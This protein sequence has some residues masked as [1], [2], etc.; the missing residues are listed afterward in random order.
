MI[1]LNTPLKVQRKLAE[2]T[3]K[4]RLQMNLTQQ[5]LAER[6]GVAL[7][8]L[9]KFEQVGGISLASFLKIQMVLGGLEDILNATQIKEGQFSSIDEVLAGSTPVRQR[10]KRR[11]K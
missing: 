5:E 7:A 4:R 9:R 8:T 3:R 6:S 10:G 2:N 1:V 11:S